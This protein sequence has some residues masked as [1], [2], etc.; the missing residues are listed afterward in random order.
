MNIKIKHKASFAESVSDEIKQALVTSASAPSPKGKLFVFT[1]PSGAGKS[2]LAQVILRE[3]DFFKKVVT[4]TT[5]AMREGERADIDQHF[6]SRDQFEEHIA[7][8]E[9]F[10]YATVYGNYYG[11]LKKEVY[12]IM[13]SGKSV[14]FVVDVQGALAI[15]QKYPSAIDVFIKTPSLSVLKKRLIKRGT[16]EMSV[17]E[18]RMKT[19]KD[20]LKLESKFS[21]IIVNDDLKLAI[22]E[23]QKLV[24]DSLK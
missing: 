19:A 16:D 17:I 6:I 15:K 9:L 23:V 7:K 12:E 5:R 20:E 14:L 4:C 13:D 11:S 24:V 10:E 2:T 21:H 3:F 18:Q 22:K 8:D 1:G